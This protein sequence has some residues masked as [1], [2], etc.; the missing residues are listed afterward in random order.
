MRDSHQETSANTERPEQSSNGT[1]PASGQDSLS[2]GGVESSSNVMND[3]NYMLFTDET[4]FVE[5]FVLSIFDKKNFAN[6]KKWYLCTVEI[7]NI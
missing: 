3:P 5:N 6:P 1:T 7:K 2:V 4:S